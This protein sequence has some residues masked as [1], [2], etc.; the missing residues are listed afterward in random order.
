MGHAKA[1]SEPQSSTSIQLFMVGT[2][3][4]PVHGMAAATQAVFD[5]LVAE[6]WQVEKLDTAPNSLSRRVVARL[7]RFPA[8]LRVWWRLATAKWRNGETRPVAYIALSGG[9][10]QIYDLVTVAICRVR[11]LPCVLHHHSVAYLSKKSFIT[12]LLC[13]TS[14]LS[15]AAHIVLCEPMRQRLEALYEVRR[16]TVLSNSALFPLDSEPLERE[17]LRVVG[18]LSN[19]TREKGGECVIAL[20][21]AIRQR[22]WPLRV[23]VA[24]PCHDEHLVEAL[25]ASAEEGILEWLGPVYGEDKSQFWKMTDVFVFPTQYANEAE[26]LVLWEAL[27]AG[28]PV[29]S[30]SRGCIASQLEFGGIALDPSEDFVEE[31]LKTLADWQNPARFREV[32]EQARRRYAEASTTGVMAWAD[33]VQLLERG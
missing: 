9:W 15:T 19:V 31:S 32:S 26:P 27:A 1:I 24:G 22:N 8:V 7:G 29:I 3:P 17:A 21:R 18:F 13:Q 11:G 28:V 4:P 16:V 5:R 14:G 10:G 30:Y 20:A 2:F 33:F 12:R 6:G 25:N 23:V